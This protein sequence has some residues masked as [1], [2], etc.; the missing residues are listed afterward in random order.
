MQILKCYLQRTKKKKN[1]PTFGCESLQNY[2]SY[3]VALFQGWKQVVEVYCLEEL[4]PDAGKQIVKSQNFPFFMKFLEEKY[5]AQ[6]DN[7]I[8]LKSKKKRK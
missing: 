3:A 7:K 8:C 2:D 4:F 6:K 5:V 1:I